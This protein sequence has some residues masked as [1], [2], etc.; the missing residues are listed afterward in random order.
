[1]NNWRDWQSVAYLLALPAL[2]V[3]SWQQPA[4]HV[5]PYIAI[6]ILVIGASAASATTTRTC[7]S[8]ALRG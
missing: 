1:M 8:G 2:V 7:R 5:V 6:L 4:F 3:W